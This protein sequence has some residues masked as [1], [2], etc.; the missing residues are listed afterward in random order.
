MVSILTTPVEPSKEGVLKILNYQEPWFYTRL[1]DNTEERPFEVTIGHMKVCVIIKQVP[2]YPKFFSINKLYLYVLFIF[3]YI[4][5]VTKVS[6]YFLN[7]IIPQLKANNRL[8]FAQD[9]A[10]NHAIVRGK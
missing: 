1:F 5:V 9:V 8:K 6:E 7:N 3:I 2:G 4:F 10:L